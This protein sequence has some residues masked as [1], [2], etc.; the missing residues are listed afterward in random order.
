MTVTVEHSDPSS[1]SAAA[2]LS[3][4]RAIGALE[5]LLSERLQTRVR[6]VRGEAIEHRRADPKGAARNKRAYTRHV[7]SVSGSVRGSVPDHLVQDGTLTVF[8]KS[9]AQIPVSVPDTVL[10]TVTGR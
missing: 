8:V 10:A 2:L 5:S 9:A 7:L 6:H 1:L 4:E 3:N